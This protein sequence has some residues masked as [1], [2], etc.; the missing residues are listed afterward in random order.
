MKTAMVC[1]LGAALTGALTLWADV[2]YTETVH[3]K[4][5][6]MI[7]MAKSMANNPM[8]ARM[9][10]AFEDQ[11]YTI[12]IKGNKMARVGK[13]TTTI[14]D[15]DAGSITNINHS[16]KTYTVITF[17][18]LKQMSERMQQFAGGRGGMDFD[19]KVKKTGKTK[20]INGQTATETII[21][22]TEKGGGPT[23]FKS[24]VWIAPSAAG[25]DEL[26]AFHM[27]VAQQSEAALG[28]GPM[29]GGAG[30][31]MAAA[32]RE[33][34]QIGGVPV[35]VDTQISGVSAGPMGGGGDADPDAVA[36]DSVSISSNWSSA[37]V[38]DSLF[39]IPADYKKQ[40]R[41]F[42]PRG[43]GGR[44]HGGEAPPQ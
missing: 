5:G 30:R 15:L 40:E 2:T 4:G 16:R 12:Y 7:D 24:D 14:T 37:P 39:A 32:S 44:A 29:M 43:P 22:A 23:K 38:D 26:R 3:Y 18:Q 34:L 42:G 31:A 28:A 11:S 9:G 8:T 35:E 6:T 17:D 20:E 1:A 19:I 36:I 10:Q 33:A 25:A 13:N 27:K 41:Q 21:T